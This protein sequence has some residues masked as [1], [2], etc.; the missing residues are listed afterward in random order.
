MP[1]QMIHILSSLFYGLLYNQGK[2]LKMPTFREEHLYKRN[3]VFFFFHACQNIFSYYYFKMYY[4][5][6]KY[7]TFTAFNLASFRKIPLCIF[8]WAKS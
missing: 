6:L 5:G 7:K 1:L 4:P 2:P 8:F 3:L